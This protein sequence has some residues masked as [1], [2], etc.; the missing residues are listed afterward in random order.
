MK[1]ENSTRTPLKG[2]G[3]FIDHL[4]HENPNKK[5]NN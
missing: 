1:A 5:V 4:V 3:H 2:I